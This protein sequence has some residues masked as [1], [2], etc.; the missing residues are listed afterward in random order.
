MQYLKKLIEARPFLQRVPDQD[1]IAN[2]YSG[3]NHL[4]A[5]R[6]E[7]Y[8]F[9]YTPTG[10]PV[11]VNMGLISGAKVKANWYNPRNGERIYDGE[12]ENKGKQKFIAPA[13]GR[14]RDWVLV[15]DD[16][17]SGYGF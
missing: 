8:A 9:I 4:Q 11:E 7:S 6:G 10:L 1:L 13:Q 15:L 3:Y 16:V 17:E 14:D 12:Y 5:C 2:Q